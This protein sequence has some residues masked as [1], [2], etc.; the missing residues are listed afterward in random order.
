MNLAAVF[1]EKG[2]DMEK[3]K[4]AGYG[5]V[6]LAG[7]VLLTGCELRN[8][9]AKD[10][11]G[12]KDIIMETKQEVQEETVLNRLFVNAKDAWVGDIMPFADE[13]GIYL[14]YLYETD[15]NGVAYHPIH[16]FTTSDLCTYRDD[17]EILPFGTELESP[18]LAIGTGC[19]LKDREGKYHCFYTG[20]NDK[21]KDLGIAKEC[22]MH[23][24]SSDNRNWEKVLEDTFYAPDSY[25]SDDFRDPFVF[26]NEEEE[27]YWLLIGAKEENKEG[28]CILNYTSLDLVT[29]ELSGTLYEQDNLYYMECPDL[30]KM[31]RWYY[32]IF[33]WNN[34]TYYRMAESM[35]GPWI[36]PEIDTFDGN[37]FYAAKTAEYQGKRYLFGFIDR[38][39]NRND[40]LGYTWAGSVCPYELVQQE[41]GTLGAKMPT[42][43]EENHFTE[44]TNWSIAGSRGSI[45]NKNSGII[46]KANE[47]A[48]YVEFGAL[49]QSMLLSCT[50][51]FRNTAKGAKAG[52][53]FGIEEDAL[54]SYPVSLD[55]ENDM[56]CYDGY[57]EGFD[58]ESDIRNQQRFDFETDREYKVNLV[59]EDEVA[60]LYMNDEKVLSNRIYSAIGKKWGL[61][62]QGGEVAFSDITVSLPQPVSSVFS[63]DKQREMY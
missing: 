39:K 19:F 26:W 53:L 13:N 12:N 4:Y 57:S 14:N 44:K 6:L 33:S 50:V 23:A 34:V 54:K 51:M 21:A 38:K 49:P 36:K 46:M 56:L 60:V 31:N 20:H 22:V 15:H 55:L 43:Y 8:S 10:E 25:S 63:V 30:F 47:E 40:K 11:G 59:V 45:E 62:A 9:T 16:R 35:N 58:M 29:W 2:A 24:V 27:C 28:S 32:L 37:A 3:K 61:F 42:Q 41:D 18:D 52:F 7:I 48:S 1:L 5:A 17:G